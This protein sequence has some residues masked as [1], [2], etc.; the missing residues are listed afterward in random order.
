MAENREQPRGAAPADLSSCVDGLANTLAAGVA[1]LAAPEGLLP[2]ELAILRLFLA[3]EHWTVTHLTQELPVKKPHVSHMVTNLVDRGLVRRRRRHDDRRVVLLMLTGRGK[4]LALR[5]HR[6]AQAYEAA[7]SE[8][9]CDEEKAAFASLTSKVM[10]NH[11]SL[12]RS[13]PA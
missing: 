10:A 13:K 8:G 1:E 12:E 11:A 4:A 7:L 5:L 2:L 6:Q 3:R 9:V